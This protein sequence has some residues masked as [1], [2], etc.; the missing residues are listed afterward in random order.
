MEVA[1]KTVLHALQEA[2]EERLTVAAR[3][4]E[5]LEGLDGRMDEL[6]ASRGATLLELA[7]HYLSEITRENVDRAFAEIRGDLEGILARK[8][9]QQ[10][11]LRHA[12]AG[13]QGPHQRR[14][15]ELASVTQRLNETVARRESL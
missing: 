4:E 5:E 8:R 10:R 11:K 15:K 7:R 3:I 6:V 1:G 14:E 12:V 2:L 9:R 13:L